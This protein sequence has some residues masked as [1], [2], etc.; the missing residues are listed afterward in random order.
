MFRWVAAERRRCLGPRSPA[1]GSCRRAAPPSLGRASPARSRPPPVRCR[2]RTRCR[3][4]PMTA[5]VRPR[6]CRCRRRATPARDH[7]PAVGLHDHRTCEVVATQVDK[8]RRPSPPRS[9]YRGNPRAQ[10]ARPGSPGQPSCFPRQ[11]RILPSGCKA[12]A[13]PPSDLPTSFSPLPRCLRTR[14]SMSPPTTAHARPR[15][16]CRRRRRF[17]RP[18]RSGRWA[19][20]PPPPRSSRGR[21][22]PAGPRSPCASRPSRAR[23]SCQSPPAPAAPHR[24]R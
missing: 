4:C 11:S 10:T 14:C 8:R 17:A 24:S 3:L 19:V 13:S 2:P 21:L 23:S 16:R 15:G 18:R 12:T 20:A 22:R 9:Q 6:S 1:S 5:H 7:D